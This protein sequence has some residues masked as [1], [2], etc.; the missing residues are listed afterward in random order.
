MQLIPLLF[1][2]G[3]GGLRIPKMDIGEHEIEFMG[4][5][6]VFTGES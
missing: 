3:D 6:S 2:I 1:P 4:V 5:T